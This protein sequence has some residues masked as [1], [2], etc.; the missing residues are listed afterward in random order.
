MVR[1]EGGSGAG[2]GG[3]GVVMGGEAAGVGYYDL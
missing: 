3:S 1:N 2:D